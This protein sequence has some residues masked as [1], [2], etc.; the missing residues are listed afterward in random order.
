MNIDIVYEDEAICIVNKPSGLIVNNAESVKVS[1][2][3]SW[4]EQ[5]H[6]IEFIETSEFHSRSGIVHRLDKDTSGILCIAKTETAFYFLKEQFLNR[7][8]KKEYVALVHD[9]LIPPIGEIIAPV[10]R[11]PWNREHFGVLSDGREAIT[12]YEVI[13]KY[14][15]T[16]SENK[17]YQTENYSLVK[18]FP[19]TGRTHQLRVHMKYINHSVVG[20]ILYSGRKIYKKDILWSKRLMLHAQYITFINPQTKVQ[21]T[22]EAVL[23]QDF[24]IPL[25]M[26]NIV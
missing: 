10:G 17:R 19:L 21:Q 20:D 12:K 5:R 8:I 4:S 16:K 1:T 25:S 22:L 24:L 23:P 13:N 9:F 2:L 26:L 15:P 14:S 6:H 18:L 11:L 3:A 7:T